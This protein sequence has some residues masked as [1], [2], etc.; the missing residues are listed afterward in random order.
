MPAE[1]MALMARALPVLVT[2][3]PYSKEPAW[4]LPELGATA[5]AWE[6]GRETAGLGMAVG[7]GVGVGVGVGVGAK[8][9]MA[10][11]SRAT[12]SRPVTTSTLMA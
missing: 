10:W 7:A 8:R 11:P 9:P 5:G 3:P 4:M 6:T 1:R 12:A 2:W